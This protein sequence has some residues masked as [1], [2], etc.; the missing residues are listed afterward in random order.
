M[1]SGSPLPKKESDEIAAE[2]ENLLYRSSR[3]TRA[4]AV[5][6]SRSA[7]KSSEQ[8]ALDFANLEDPSTSEAERECGG[9]AMD[10]TGGF[11]TLGAGAGAGAGA[12]ALGGGA[13]AGLLA[14]LSSS[15][16]SK[17]NSIC[18]AICLDPATKPVFAGAGAGADGEDGEAAGSG[19][20][21]RRTTTLAGAAAVGFGCAAGAE[22]ALC[23]TAG[24]DLK[25]CRLVGEGGCPG[26]SAA[27]STGSTAAGA[28][29][30]ALHAT[31]SFAHASLVS[32]SRACLYLC[33]TFEVYSGGRPLSLVLPM[34][35][36]LK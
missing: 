14:S 35:C 26:K 24:A 15:S 11:V 21:A 23:T 13:G 36:D 19:G 12:A 5:S 31:F 16:K 1:S 34:P 28:C 6:D 17:S 25:L 33:A 27:S 20:A 2:L 22:G 4:E 30:A 7:K 8:M 32:F 18:L 10:A 29:A 9:A 3:S